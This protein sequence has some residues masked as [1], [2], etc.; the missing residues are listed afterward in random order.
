MLATTLKKR[1]IN[2]TVTVNEVTAVTVTCYGPIP[3]SW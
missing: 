2:I 3:I 1:V